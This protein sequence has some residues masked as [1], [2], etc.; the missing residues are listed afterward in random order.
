MSSMK[1]DKAIPIIEE[2][3]LALMQAVPDLVFLLGLEDSYIDIF[4]AADEDLFL[5]REQLSGRSVLE[6]L[7][8]PVGEGC[9]AALGNLTSPRDVS[10]FSY[11]LLIGG[12]LNGCISMEWWHWPIV[13]ISNGLQSDPGHISEPLK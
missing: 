4:S 13:S 9:M 8:S 10:S 6:V 3:G 5:P 1:G 11:E 7:P 2:K 12:D